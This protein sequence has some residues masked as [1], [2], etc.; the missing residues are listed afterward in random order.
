[1]A[2]VI[3]KTVHG[4]EL[5][6]CE[7]QCNVDC[8]G[9]ATALYEQGWLKG[10]E[11]SVVLTREQY[12]TLCFKYGQC[13]MESNLRKD[14]IEKLKVELKQAQKETAREI[15]RELYDACKDDTY[16]Q[17]VVDFSALESLAKQNGVELDQ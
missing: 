5:K 8:T 10:N 6:H 14:E 15:L 11:G 13:I 1:M 12:K 7:V 3:C 17:V 4:K 16:G 9:I 2:K